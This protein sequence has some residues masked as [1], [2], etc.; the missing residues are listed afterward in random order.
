[1]EKACAP[2][3]DVPL[4]LKEFASRF[5]SILR[6]PAQREQFEIL[7]LGLIASENKTLAGIHQCLTDE[8]GYR[9]L[10]N[11]MTESPWDLN[12]M[13]KTRL[14]LVAQELANY[15]PGPRVV[16]IDS[17]LVH[18]SGEHIHGVYWYYDY[19]NRSFC[20]GQKLVVATFVAPARTVPLGMKIYHRGFLQEQ[21]LYLEHTKPS[22]D[23]PQEKWDEFESLVAKYEQNRKEFRTQLDLAGDLVDETERHNIPVDAYVLDGGFLDIGLMDKIET[24]ERAWISR[25][26][27]NRLVQLPSGKFDTAEAFAKSLPRSAF[28]PVTLRTRTG[29]ER[30]Y[31]AFAKNTKIKFWKKLRVV[32]TYD[33]EAL[34]GEPRIFVSNK[35]NW[36]QAQKILQLYLFRGP[37]EHFFRDEKQEIGFEDCQQ[38]LEA[39][40]LRYWELCLVAYTFLELFVRVDYL[41]D[42]PVPLLD[43]IGQ[44]VRFVEMQLLQSFISRVRDRI[45]E[46]VDPEELIKPIFRKRLNGLAC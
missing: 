11:F 30:T 20:L 4:S 25:L 44:K 17:T 14:N 35:L 6:H 7:L 28:A 43:S 2:I 23:A 34:T 45:L 41:D 19:V 1:M 13:R 26:A 42:M 24:Y 22:E 3:S 31:W 27:K 21:K 40:V 8:T 39:A 18:H 12:E 10:H 9:A 38:R 29:E 16:A 5:R 36:I 37:I 33:N 46:G 32:I 15:G